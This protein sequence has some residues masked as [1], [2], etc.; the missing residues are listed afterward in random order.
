MESLSS[1]NGF[2]QEVILNQGRLFLRDW[3][4][5]EHEC[6]WIHWT[7]CNSIG[8]IPFCATFEAVWSPEKLFQRGWTFKEQA[9]SVCSVGMSL[10]HAE[11]V[12]FVLCKST[13]SCRGLCRRKKCR[14]RASMYMDTL[15]THF[16]HYLVWLLSPSAHC[17]V[18]W[19][20]T[21]KWLCSVRGAHLCLFFSLPE[22]LYPDMTGALIL[23]QIQKVFGCSEC[24][25]LAHG[26]VRR[27]FENARMDSHLLGGVSRQISWRV[28][29]SA[30][31][32]FAER[33]FM[34]DK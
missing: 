22:I 4:L 28:N 25:C 19:F 14:L 21:R 26:A 3:I 11:I 24:S 10:F 16:V 7:L 2:Q 27:K 5:P 20:I 1:R 17:P 13:P 32:S 23:L 29:W 34:V 18:T 12:C 8:E 31:S 9:C 6:I 33:R 15:D 30:Q